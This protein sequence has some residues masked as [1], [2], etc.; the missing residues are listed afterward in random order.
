MRVTIE[1]LCA[2]NAT[3]GSIIALNVE[4]PDDGNHLKR[5]EKN[6]INN[7]PNQKTGIES[8][9]MAKIIVIVS[10]HEYCFM[11]DI[12]PHGIPIMIAIIIANAE[13]FSV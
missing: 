7:S 8:P 11:A 6:R 3:E 1:I 4:N 12:I 10:N 5:T 13:S 2:A 9:I